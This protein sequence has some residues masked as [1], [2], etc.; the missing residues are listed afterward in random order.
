[1]ARFVKCFLNAV[2]RRFP[3]GTSQRD[4]LTSSFVVAQLLGHPKGCKDEAADVRQECWLHLGFVLLSPWSLG[5]H[6][7]QPVQNIGEGDDGRDRVYL[8]VAISIV[9]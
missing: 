4:K 7:V 5:V 6:R 3:R 9:S 8:Q 1:L 2:K